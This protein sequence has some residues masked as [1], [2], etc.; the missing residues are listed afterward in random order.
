VTGDRKASESANSSDSLESFGIYQL[1]R[2]LFEDFWN[3]SEMSSFSQN[4]SSRREEALSLFL[5]EPR[6][7]G[8][9]EDHMSLVTSL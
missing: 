2:Q 8:C 4:R 6:Y 9:Y 3:D 1:A 7:L 5:F